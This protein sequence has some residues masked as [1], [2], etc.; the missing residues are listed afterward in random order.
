MV[1]GISSPSDE[2]V[3]HVIWSFAEAAVDRATFAHSPPSLP[4]DIAGGKIRD[5]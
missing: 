5:K 2:S 4:R 1:N 3:H